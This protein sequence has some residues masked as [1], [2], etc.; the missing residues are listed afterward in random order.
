MKAEN[1]DLVTEIV[2]VNDPISKSVQGLSWLICMYI[3]H[4]CIFVFEMIL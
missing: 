3:V 2:K 4:F 1:D